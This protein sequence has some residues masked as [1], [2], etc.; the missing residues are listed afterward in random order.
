MV[1]IAAGSGAPSSIQNGGYIT[2]GNISAYGYESAFTY[3]FNHGTQ[4]ANTSYKIATGIKLNDF[5]SSLNGAAVLTDNSGTVGA[6][7]RLM[8]GYLDWSG[9]N[10]LNGHIAKLIY[11]PARL[12]NAKLQQLST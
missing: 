4:L 11:Y 3:D 9:G 8:I 5:A 10:R 2:S 7:Q 1:Y 6:N 12:T